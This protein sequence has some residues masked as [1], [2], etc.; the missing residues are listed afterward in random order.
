[1]PNPARKSLVLPRTR[2]AK[3]TFTLSREAVAFLETEKQKRGRESTSLVLEELIKEC[4]EKGNTKKID[5]AITNYYDSL[6][7]EERDENSRWGEFAENQ[8]PLD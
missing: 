6:T 3:K 5:L 4:R 1:M 8:F 2:K 7:S